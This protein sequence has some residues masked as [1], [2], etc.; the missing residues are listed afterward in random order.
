LNQEKKNWFEYAIVILLSMLV[1]LFPIAHTATIKA[2]LFIGAFTVWFAKMA[3]QREWHF[4]KTSIDW[5]LLGYLFF[6]IASLFSSVDRLA[7]ANAIKKEMIINFI[8]VYI[9]V[10]NLKQTSH[11]K[12]VL[13]TILFG[14]LVMVTYGFYDYFIT[15]KGNLYNPDIRFYSLSSDFAFFSAYLVTTFPFIFIAFFYLKKLRTKIFLFPLFVLNILALYLNHQRG[16]WIAVFT[17]CFFVLL[18]LKKWKTLSMFV[19][20]PVLIYMLLP[21]HVFLRH[22]KLMVESGTIRFMA[23]TGSIAPRI[24]VWKFALDEIAKNPF[25]GYGL[26]RDNF[27]KKYPQFKEKFGPTLFHAHNIFIDTALQ[28]GIGGLIVFLLIIMKM[29]QIHWLS[30]KKST[31]NLQHYLSLSI[32]VI[33]IGYFTRNFFDTLF[34]SDSGS[35]IWFLWAIGIS[36]YIHQ[37]KTND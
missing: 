22:E 30:F 19:L 25:T 12:S 8:I 18:I 20:I 2:I 27:A 31:T 21:T 24:T 14:N 7:T 32:F 33:T 16:A 28:M 5:F 29:L 36:Q 26:G 6:G 10:N 23:G 9:I 1:F 13:I 37:V 4:Q 11:N 34:V 15:Q 35:F 17:G 3:V